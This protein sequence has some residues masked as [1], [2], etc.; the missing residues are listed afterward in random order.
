VKNFVIA[1]ADALLATEAGEAKAKGWPG[2]E[3]ERRLGKRPS[4]S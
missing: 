3:H 2:R 4:M 1:M